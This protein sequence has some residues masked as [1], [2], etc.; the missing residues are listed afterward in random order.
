MTVLVVAP[1][2]DDETL[3]CGG[4]LLKHKASG[5][6]IHWLIMTMVRQEYG[7]PEEQEKNRAKQIQEVSNRYAFDSIHNLD[8]QPAG[9]DRVPLGDLINKV[10]I[11]FG[12]V[13]PNT[14][15]LPFPGDAHSDHDVTFKACF[16]NTKIFRHP[17]VKSVRIYET[18]SE[19]DFGPG[20]QDQGFKPNL[21][22]N[23]E[24]FLDKKLEILNLYEGEILP[25]PFPRSSEAVK[26]LALLRGHQTQTMAAESFMVTRTIE[27]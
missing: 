15:Y 19:T 5:E 1:H 12:K 22:I 3:G 18:I 4:T 25:P 20:I 6:D 13:K 2:P 24:N 10:G 9:L 26:S 11:V 21:F 8:L 16:P 27:L 7:F 17:Y 23:I 14:V